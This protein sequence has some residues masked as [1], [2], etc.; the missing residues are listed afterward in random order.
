LLF[1]SS[2][3]PHSQVSWKHITFEILIFHYTATPTHS[4]TYHDMS[5]GVIFLRNQLEPSEW[6]QDDW[7]LVVLKKCYS[8]FQIWTSV[9]IGAEIPDML[10]TCS[11]DNLRAIYVA[12]SNFCFLKML[13]SRWIIGLYHHHQ[14]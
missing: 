14:L 1:W 2:G 4:I 9:P 6:L 8:L 5:L 13:K 12:T 11:L 3:Y 7:L 10:G